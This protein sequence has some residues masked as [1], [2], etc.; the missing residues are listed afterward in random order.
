MIFKPRTTAALEDWITP[1]HVDVI[2]VAAPTTQLERIE[3]RARELREAMGPRYLCHAQN[4]V[5]RLDER[6][7]YRPRGGVS[8][9]DRAIRRVA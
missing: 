5:R 9:N 1:P 4:R 6:V 7:G 3:Q 2:K 8:A